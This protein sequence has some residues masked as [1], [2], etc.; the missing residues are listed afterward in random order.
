VLKMYGDTLSFSQ[1]K[2]QEISSTFQSL[3]TVWVH[4]S[5]CS[6]SPLSFSWSLGDRNCDWHYLGCRLADTTSS[7]DHQDSS[8]YGQHC[9]TH[10]V[11][12]SA[13]V[14]E[15]QVCSPCALSV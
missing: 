12:V 8:G 15:K 11:F 7:R 5:L 9:S 14:V 4:V 10:T 6:V 2:V 3:K 1:W 13:D